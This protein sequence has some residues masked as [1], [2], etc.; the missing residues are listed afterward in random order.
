MLQVCESFPQSWWN[1]KNAGERLTLLLMTLQSAFESRTLNHYFIK[2]FNLLNG[3]PGDLDDVVSNTIDKIISE[4]QTL[5]PFLEPHFNIAKSYVDAI[6]DMMFTNDNQ[7][8]VLGLTNRLSQP[9]IYGIQAHAAWKQGR[10]KPT[11][12]AVR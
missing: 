4:P 11:V 5:L 9:I 2:S 6:D 10:T 3:I 8:D 1:S 7:L 12:A